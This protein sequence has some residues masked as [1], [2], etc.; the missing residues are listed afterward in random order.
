[1]KTVQSAHWLVMF[2]LCVI[3]GSFQSCVKDSCDQLTYTYMEYEPTYMTRAAFEDAV[4][5]EKARELQDPGKILVNED[6]LFVN[7]IGK[8]IHIIDNANPASPQVL[9]FLRVPGNYDMAIHCGKLYVD[10]SVDLLVFDLASAE[11]PSLISR[12]TNAFP[13]MLFYK[14]YLADANRGVVVEWIGKAVEGQYNCQTGIPEM[15]ELNQLDA[16][17][18]SEMFAS[19]NARQV[20]PSVPGKAGSMSR[21]TVQKEHL[22]IVSPTELQ[23]YNVSNCAE[24]TLTSSKVLELWGG[25]AEMVSVL[26]DLILIG[27]N[28]GVLLYSSDSPEDPQYLSTFEHVQACDPVVG[29]GNFAFVTLRDGREIQC[30][31]N[32]TNQLDVLSIADPMRPSLLISYTMTHPHGLGIDQNLLFVADGTDGLKVFDATDPVKVGNK[33]IAQF[34]TYQGYDVIPHDGMLIMVG[35]DGIAQFDYTDPENIELIGSIPVSQ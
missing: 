15:W 14:G 29:S 31:N 19:G 6:W 18:A 7:E 13:H 22:Y 8:G 33:L 26:N 34:D 5:V 17:S 2:C 1:M 12:T 16:Q 20:N 23:V 27:T 24:P 11:Q 9:S 35:K 32:F 4:K 21:F 3:A 28:V 25:E 10:S 30:G